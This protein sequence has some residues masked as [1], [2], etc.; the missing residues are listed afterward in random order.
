MKTITNL[1]GEK[2]QVPEEAPERIA[3]I[4]GPAYEALTVL[5][6]E[7][8]IVVCADVQFENFPWAK[9]VYSRISDLP[10]L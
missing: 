9:K 7:D 6:A 3:A 4:Y 10:Y 1:D 2:L 5:G 8:R